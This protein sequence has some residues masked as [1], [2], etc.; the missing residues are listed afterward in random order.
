MP[1][2]WGVKYLTL[3]SLLHGNRNSIIYKEIFV[4][5]IKARRNDSRCTISMCHINLMKIPIFFIKFFIKLLNFQYFL[6]LYQTFLDW[7]FSHFT[8]WSPFRFLISDFWKKTIVKIG[9][10]MLWKKG[11][12]KIL[13]GY[14]CTTPSSSNMKTKHDKKEKP[15]ANGL[16]LKP[17]N[18]NN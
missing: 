2:A 4:D 18:G 3:L 12:N 14:C 9:S 6:C 5:W 13:G 16:I 7:Q 10:Y 8:K 11:R 1:A 15:T 17:L